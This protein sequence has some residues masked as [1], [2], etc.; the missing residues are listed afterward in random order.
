MKV[1]DRMKAKADQA[2]HKI[3]G[4]DTELSLAC[5]KFLAPYWAK[6]K[7]EEDMKSA[8]EELAAVMKA[9]NK[10]SVAHAGVVIICQLGKVQSDKIL[11]R[12]A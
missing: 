11:V 8:K 12:G 10:T 1:R 2:Q 6:K 3:P 9:H 4:T 5:D 7:A